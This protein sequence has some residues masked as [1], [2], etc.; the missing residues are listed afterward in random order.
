MTRSVV[1]TTPIPS[2]EEFGNSLGLSKARQKS[3]M[4]IMTGVGKGSTG[5]ARKARRLAPSSDEPEVPRLYGRA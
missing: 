2:L 1:V 4:Q 5:V 3:I